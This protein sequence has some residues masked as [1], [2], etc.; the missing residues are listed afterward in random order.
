MYRCYSFLKAFVCFFSLM[1]AFHVSCSFYHHSKK[2][3]IKA[4]PCKNAENE[5]LTAKW[6][7]LSLAS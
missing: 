7:I 2:K 6:R 1:G 5:R 4:N 3:D